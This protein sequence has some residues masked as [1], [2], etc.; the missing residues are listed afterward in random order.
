MGWVMSELDRRGLYF[1]DSRTSA[2]TVAAAKAQSYALPHMRRDIFLDNERN[3]D[4]I[5]RQLEKLLSKAHRQG[6]AVGIGH[7]YGET[8]EVLAEVLPTLEL[9]GVKLSLISDYLS[10]KKQ[11]CD[12][13]G[14]YSRLFE[15]ECQLTTLSLLTNAH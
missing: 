10:P 15:P 6:V 11:R 14:S 1:I 7:P 2:S 3:H 8:I 13:Q 5:R 9:R 4:A 12:P